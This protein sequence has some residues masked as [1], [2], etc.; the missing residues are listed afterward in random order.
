MGCVQVKWTTTYKECA[1]YFYNTF[2]DNLLKLAD[3]E[4]IRYRNIR[5]VFGFDS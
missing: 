1:G 4:D 3:A 2:Y 5:I